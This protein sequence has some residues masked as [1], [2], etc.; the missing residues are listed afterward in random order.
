MT[1]LYVIMNPQWLNY[2]TAENYY[3][4]KNFEKA[5]EYYEKSISEGVSSPKA[6]LHLADSYVVVRRFQEAA[7]IYKKYLLLYPDDEKVHKELAETLFW[8]GDT[9]GA[10]KEYEKI[11]GPK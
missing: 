10:L 5:I 8:S 9:E 2:R 3:H 4:N 6:E 1:I 7:L 11:L